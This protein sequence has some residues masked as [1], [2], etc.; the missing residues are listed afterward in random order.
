MPIHFDFQP[1]LSLITE[2]LPRLIEKREDNHRNIRILPFFCDNSQ[3]W[4]Y[5]LTRNERMLGE[6]GE[7]GFMEGFYV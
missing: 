1:L 7:K 6:S 2:Y 3:S 5:A 4:A